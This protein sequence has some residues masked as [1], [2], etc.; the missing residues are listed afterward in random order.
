[1][2]PTRG[3]PV[4]LDSHILVVLAEPGSTLL[5]LQLVPEE[6]DV[7]PTHSAFSHAPTDS[8]NLISL[9]QEKI[10]PPINRIPTSAPLRDV[11]ARLLFYT[12]KMCNVEEKLVSF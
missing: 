3:A 2:L 10:S 8:I 5:A 4:G 9:I 1:M 7:L 6:P 12:L 11:D